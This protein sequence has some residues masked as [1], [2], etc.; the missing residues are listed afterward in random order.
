LFVTAK[1]TAEIAAAL[2][3][4]HDIRVLY[5]KHAILYTNQ[6]AAFNC[7]RVQS[8]RAKTSTPNAGINAAVLHYTERLKRQLYIKLGLTVVEPSL[9]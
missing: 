4:I 2:K 8:Q 1:K 6:S 7:D 5:I 9:P 3:L